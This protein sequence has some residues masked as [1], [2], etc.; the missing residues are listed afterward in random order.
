MASVKEIVQ[1]IS[2]CT[3]FFRSQEGMLSEKLKEES[4]ASMAATVVGYIGKLRTLDAPGA[5]A[6]N[7]AISSSAF[8]GA[9]KSDFATAVVQRL[10]APAGD[11]GNAASK[12]V[13]AAPHNYPTESD[14]AYI[15]DKSKSLQ[16]VSTTS[17]RLL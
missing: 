5:S 11:G 2:G 4:V 14:W 7:A 1:Y 13:M 15:R 6:L 3:E 16:Q 10:T 8:P 12:Q 17:A 9:T